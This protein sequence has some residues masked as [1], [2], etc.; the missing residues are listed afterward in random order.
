MSSST[1][2]GAPSP[3]PLSS[4]RAIR[5][6]ASKAEQHRGRARAAPILQF[7]AL[8]TDVAAAAWAVP[9]L[10][11]RSRQGAKATNGGKTMKTTELHW[12][13]SFSEARAKAATTGKTLFLD[14]FKPT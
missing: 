12:A 9:I 14:F 3:S 13:S 2:S 1:S 6:Q 10:H 8:A 7:A 4:A 5:F 11:H